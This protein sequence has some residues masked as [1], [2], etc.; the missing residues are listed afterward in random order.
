MKD[1]DGRNVTNAFEDCYVSYL[2]VPETLVSAYKATSPWSKFGNIVALDPYDIDP[3]QY[4]LVKD[5]DL[6]SYGNANNQ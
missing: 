6:G 4:T 2:H 1:A 3:S 5:L